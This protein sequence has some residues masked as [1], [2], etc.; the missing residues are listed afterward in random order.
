MKKMLKIIIFLLI[1]LSICFFALYSWHKKTI[2]YRELIVDENAIVDKQIDR[3]RVASYNIKTLN[4]GNSLQAVKNDLTHLEAD[5][6]ALQEVD[7]NAFRSNKMDMVKA[8]AKDTPY[9]YSYF[10]PSMWVID[11]YYGLGIISKFPIKEVSSQ[12]L[13]T[14]L[15]EEPRILS[16][17]IIALPNKDINVY[18]THLSFRNRDDRKRQIA[19]I[20][21]NLEAENSIMLGDFNTFTFD[22]FFT[23][24]KMESINNLEKQFISF[25]DFGFP[26]NIFYS[27]EFV[28]ENANVMPTTFSDHHMLYID[29]LLQ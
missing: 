26:D 15:L 2:N 29:L 27:P 10:F 14:Q 16:K 13:P 1:L 4:K 20:Q 3:I 8:I 21:S 19:F 25:K 5:I 22:D 7:C 24:P 28:G 18:N 23:L 12:Q 6:V 9:K 11:G 17:A